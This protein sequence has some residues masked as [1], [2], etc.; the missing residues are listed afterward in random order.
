MEDAGTAV[1]GGVLN[2]VSGERK[3]SSG[4]KYGYGYYGKK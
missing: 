1:I 4:R 3:G 2:R